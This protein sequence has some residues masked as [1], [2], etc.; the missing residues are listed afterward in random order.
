MENQKFTWMKFYTELADTLLKYKNKRD[1][2]II[3]IK[4]VFEKAQMP[5]PRIEEEVGE[6]YDLDPFTIFGFF[7]KGKQKL[8]KRR[9]FCKTLKDE[10]GLIA[11]VPNDFDGVPVFMPLSAVM[12]W[13]KFNNNPRGEH[14]ID[15]LWEMFEA[16]IEYEKLQTKINA[17]NFAN[18]FD[19]VMKQRGVSW[20]LTFALFWIRPDFYFSLDSKNRNMLG[21]KDLA[22]FANSDY[23]AKVGNL[24]KIPSG[25]KYLEICEATR[26]FVKNAELPFDSI[27]G[28]SFYAETEVNFKDKVENRKVNYWTY[29]PGEHASK[30]SELKNAGIMAI[31]WDKIGELGSY[32]SN[33]EMRVAL[34]EKYGK[35]FKQTNS[36]LACWE[37]V[38]ELKIGDIIFAKRGRDKLLC[39]G[40]VVGDYER[41][42]ERDSYKNVR[43]VEWEKSVEIDA[44]EMMAMKT[45]TNVTKAVNFVRECEELFNACY[46]MEDQEEVVQN[47]DKYS[48]DDFEKEV[49]L[50]K[51][52]RDEII[53][54]LKE[55][56]NIILQGA[57]GVGKTFVAKKLA[58]ML[59]G[60]EDESRVKIIQFHQSYSYED[61]IEGYRPQND[62]KFEI[63]SGVFKEFCEKAVNDQDHEYYLIIDEI[64]RGNLSK[65]FGELFML[66]ENDKRG[67]ESLHLLYSGD[68]FSVPENLMIIGTM[69]TADR[70]LAMLDYALR[71]R[72][73]F[74]EI[75]PAFE[76][77]K[78]QKYVENIK[79]SSLERFIGALKE[80]NKEIRNDSSL[81]KGFRIGHSYFCKLTENMTEAEIKKALQKIITYEIGP[82]IEEYWFDDSKKAE[83][84]IEKLNDSLR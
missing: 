21:Q 36:A 48:E 12:F 16:A 31:G 19:T 77:P 55:K 40:K 28:F 11:E 47:F 84:I 50:D 23:L 29:S 68:E 32:K 80:V 72:F 58:Y 6:I 44:P 74:F 45:L 10:F 18:C 64:N 51:E 24:D 46:G 43:K 70:S 42:D 37:F 60:E 69:N 82:L 1:V 73:A 14:D 67:K 65:I 22:I 71:R 56:K 20:G 8:E 76:S 2:L 61:F 59:L 78:F 17:E 3:K 75:R 49:F 38:N 81:G 7:N 63:V 83:G 52:F 34:Q 53:E 33:E 79:S 4:N 15:N 5:L 9:M 26:N 62:G 27:A 66:V 41:D 35:E 57:P 30:W 25:K 13:R 39:R 54:V